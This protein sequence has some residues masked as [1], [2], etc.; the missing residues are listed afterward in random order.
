VDP[1]SDPASSV[2]TFVYA[3]AGTFTASVTVTDNCGL[4]ATD[5]LTVVVF[6]LEAACH[7]RAQ[8]IA[9]SV[10][11][12]FPGQ[13]ARLYSCEDIFSMFNGGLTGS[14]LG[15]GRM[16]H[17]YQLAVAME[18]LTWEE[19]LDWHLNGT[20]WGLLTQ[21]DRFSKALEGID[22][23]QLFEMVM[24]GDASVQN[25]RTAVRT[26]ARYGADFTDALDRL[27]EGASPG[28][29][30]KFYRTAQD[31]DLDASTLDAYLDSGVSL[32]E[33]GHAGRMA[34]RYEADLELV[35][36]AHAGGQ[37][38][39]EIAQAYRLADG[40]TTADE[41]L[42]M[43]SHA[44]REQTREA[45]QGERQADHE[46][47]LA[48]RLAEQYGVTLD[49]VEDLLGGCAGDWSCVRE[50]LRTQEDTSSA[51]SSDPGIAQRISRQYRVSVDQVW[52]V[53]YGSCAEDW[54]CVK[55]QFREGAHPNKH[56]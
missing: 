27:A 25:I 48:T 4:K 21:L 6:D 26:A 20:G 29:L 38:W 45:D 10:D 36:S 30:T 1:G 18:E 55:R 42:A 16:W 32:T 5:T 47:Q 15:F 35:A 50:A 7:P 17:A 53:F 44:F 49:A 22:L 51:A 2:A 56:Q 14:Q 28:E 33:L 52:S 13:A 8:Q 3:S 54:S 24:A 34:E 31:L 37:S 40:E 41:I 46:T 23:R 11:T 9:Q 39:G 43:G 19:I 12:L